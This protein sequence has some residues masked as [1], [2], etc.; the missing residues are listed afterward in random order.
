MS[1]G[2][3][4]N[5]VVSFGVY[6]WFEVK[7]IVPETL[8][9][10]E[11]NPTLNNVNIHN[12]E[13]NHNLA[14]TEDQLKKVNYTYDYSTESY[15]KHSI[16]PY[17]RVYLRCHWNMFFPQAYILREYGKYMQN[18]ANFH[19][20]SIKPQFLVN[21]YLEREPIVTCLKFMQDVPEASEQWCKD[22]T[23]GLAETYFPIT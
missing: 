22:L 14:K 16:I 2:P 3:N 5:N 10:S 9:N 13:L 1:L 21:N 8:Y 15:I 6:D 20:F 11:G 17:N 19:S 4:S 7:N 12:I 18:T 23:N